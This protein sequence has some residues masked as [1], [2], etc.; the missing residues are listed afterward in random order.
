MLPAFPS[1]P[2]IPSIPGTPLLPGIGNLPSPKGPNLPGA[3]GNS[4]LAGTFSNMLQTVNN[5]IQ[6]PY[7]LS[8]DMLSG[9]REFDS[10]ALMLSMLEAEK[11]MN[12]TIRVINDLVKGIK[13][14][15]TL[16]V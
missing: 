4:S 9:K 3:P 6:A 12:M 10:S 1:F 16:Q 8:K 15:E 13:Q 5:E 11:K 14:L 7:Q 2:Q